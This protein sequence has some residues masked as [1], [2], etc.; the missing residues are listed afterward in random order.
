MAS[1]QL[2]ILALDGGP[3]PTVSLRILRKIENQF[4]GFLDQHDLL[5]GTSHG[6]IVSLKLATLL[7]S[8][9]PASSAIEEC[10]HFDEELV[11]IGQLTP[12]R[13]LRML[14]EGVEPG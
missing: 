9:V 12:L 3:S 13:L 11:S 1:K 2:K 10:I 5:V 14:S 6:G 8:G 7:A 4:P